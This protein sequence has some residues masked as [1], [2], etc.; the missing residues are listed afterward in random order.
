MLDQPALVRALHSGRL[1]GAGIDV[2]DPEPLPPEDPLWTAPNV[3]ISPHYAGSGN[4]NNIKR[5]A[6]GVAEN[7]R[8]FMAGEPLLHLV[9]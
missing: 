7:L 4:P 3:L 1:G 6:D 8:R 5:L 9:S 2:S